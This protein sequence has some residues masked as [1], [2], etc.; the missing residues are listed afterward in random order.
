[1]DPRPSG[2]QAGFPSAP[3][4]P[5]ANTA[6]AW[7]ADYSSRIEEL[8]QRTQV[9]K[10]Q[11]AGLTAS[12]SSRD[13]AVTVTV[14]GAGALLDLRFGARA[15]DMPRSRLAELVLSLTREA[16]AEADRKVNEVVAPLTAAGRSR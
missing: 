16:A 13:G 9:V 2:T 12:A 1:M 10:A 4:V 5:A 15:E 14:D 6:R 11:L 7:L 3:S 8:H